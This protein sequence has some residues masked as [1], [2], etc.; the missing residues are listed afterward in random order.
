MRP[1]LV[2]WSRVHGPVAFVHATKKVPNKQPGSNV[3]YHHIT[4]APG[5]CD[6]RR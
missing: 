5:W 6:Q 4:D 3:E 2:G 1:G